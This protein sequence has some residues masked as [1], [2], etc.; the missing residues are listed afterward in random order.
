MACRKCNL[1]AALH[2]CRDRA[3][4]DTDHSTARTVCR[5]LTDKSLM[6]MAFRL[7]GSF[8]KNRPSSSCVLA[9][10]NNV[11]V[12]AGNSGNTRVKCKNCPNNA[13]SLR[14]YQNENRGSNRPYHENNRQE[15]K[16]RATGD[17]TSHVAWPSPV[18]IFSSMVVD[19][20]RE[21]RGRPAGLPLWPF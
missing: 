5:S 11:W 3:S 13:E 7:L 9:H 18:T 20:L 17:H 16:A 4:C 1:N 21:P 8:G 2:S 12:Q 19:L 15:Q 10:C 6:H 14:N